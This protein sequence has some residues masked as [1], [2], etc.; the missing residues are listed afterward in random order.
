MAELNVA[1][2][3][4]PRLILHN[5]QTSCMTSHSQIMAA[6]KCKI[7]SSAMQTSK[8]TASSPARFP[9][10]AALH[11][12]SRLAAERESICQNQRIGR[13]RHVP[14]G[15]DASTPDIELL[16]R[17]ICCRRNDP[18]DRRIFLIII[19][20]RICNESRRTTICDYSSTSKTS[21]ASRQ[22]RDVKP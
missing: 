17:R 12:L 4:M 19:I 5:V 6:A 3:A 2:T 10:S 14:Q 1:T 11:T 18:R 8:R 7:F 20:T 22:S 9:E 15:A 21:R 16:S 13:R